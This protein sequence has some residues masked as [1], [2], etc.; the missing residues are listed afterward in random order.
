[1][2]WRATGDCIGDAQGTIAGDP[3]T[4]I[5]AA[6]TLMKRQG[7]NI[8]DSCM[9]SITVSRSR[10]GTLD[11]HYGKGGTAVGSQDRTVMTMSTP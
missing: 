1:M 5:I 10:T 9:V 3:G 2:T 11:T 8:A 7:Q 6:G 4:M